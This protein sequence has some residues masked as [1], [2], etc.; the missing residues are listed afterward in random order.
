[1]KK[2]EVR[3]GT[4]VTRIANRKFIVSANS[5]E[6]AFEKARDRMEKIYNGL[7]GKSECG[8]VT[9]DFCKEI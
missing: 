8:S 7:N 1:M 9:L 4:F 6:E 3:V 5:E 2:Y